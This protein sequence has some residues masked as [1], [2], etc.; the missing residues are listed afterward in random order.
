M[1]NE[2]IKKLNYM[3]ENAPDKDGTTMIRLFGIMYSNEI[4][5]NKINVTEIANESIV[6]DSYHAEISKGIRLARYVDIK[7]EVL[8]KY[9]VENY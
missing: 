9:K 5:N 8:E 1:K 2:L 4:L 7:N 6:N 3:Y